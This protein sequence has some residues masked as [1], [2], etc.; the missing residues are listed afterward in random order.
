MEELSDDKEIMLREYQEAGQICRGHDQLIRTGL[1]I[2]GAVQAAIIGFIGTTRSHSSL[3]LVLLEI[4]GLG[5]SIV[6]ILTTARLQFR[7]EGYMERA[8]C[9]ERRLG[10]YL[11][12][13]SEEYFFLQRKRIPCEWAGI[14]NKDIW[15][16]VPWIAIILYAVL[17]VRDGRTLVASFY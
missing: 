7:Y 1:I 5:L 6:V 13:V 10:M 11:Y 9:I 3:N 15:T 16:V 8:K 17:L 2:F 14:G 4:L 12:N